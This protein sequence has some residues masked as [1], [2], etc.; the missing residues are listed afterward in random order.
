M[1]TEDLWAGVTGGVAGPGRT[2]LAQPVEVQRAATAAY[3]ALV[4]QHPARRDG[5]VQRLAAAPWRI[6]SRIRV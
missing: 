4:V 2:F 6:A 5:G 3:R 1:T